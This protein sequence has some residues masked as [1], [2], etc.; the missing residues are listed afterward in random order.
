VIAIQNLYYLLCYAWRRLEERDLVS[1]DALPEKDL[2][3]LFARIL[4]IGA[5]HLLRRGLDRGYR[6]RR[7]ETSVLSGKIDI[8]A[9]LKR[10]LLEIPRAEC[11]IDELSPNIL[12]NQIVKTTVSR[13]ARTRAVDESQRRELRQL[14][15]RFQGVSQIEL[16]RAVFR[17]VQLTK[18]RAFNSFLVSVCELLYTCLLP[19]EA[20]G[21]FRFRDF[22]RD[23]DQM[24]YLFQEFLKGFYSEEQEE[25][26][27]SS[28][29][30][31][32][33]AAS[34][35]AESSDLLPNMLTD[36]FLMPKMPSDSRRVLILE[37][38][39]TP[40]A[41]QD[42]YGKRRLRSEHLYQLFAYL[43]NSR[44]ILPQGYEAEGVLIYPFA[45]RSLD[46]WYVLNGHSVRVVTIDLSQDWRQIHLQLLRLLDVA[47]ERSAP[48]VC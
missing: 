34:F 39:Y 19:E 9:T 33:D 38:K 47:R 44:T 48:L 37:A 25:F 18:D 41:L 30:I 40:N 8:S 23:E 27:V 10:L 43:K 16:S 15:G 35:S 29:R 36:V 11:V 46:E 20:T 45:G 31:R 22:L 5:K 32:W 7:I 24:G 1:I 6:D 28:S 4:I 26:A 12:H 14:A 3:N 13:L 42:H 21:D 17:R 2:P